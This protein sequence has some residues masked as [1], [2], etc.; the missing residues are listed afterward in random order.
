MDLEVIPYLYDN[1]FDMYIF[2]NYEEDLK[3]QNTLP[4]TFMDSLTNDIYILNNDIIYSYIFYFFCMGIIHSFSSMDYSFSNINTMIL[5]NIYLIYLINNVKNKSLYYSLFN[6]IELLGLSLISL[7]FISLIN[8]NLIYISPIIYVILF[9][10]FLF[11]HRKV[12]LE[13]NK[14]LLD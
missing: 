5:L 6:N 13:I 14:R 9:R 2:N 10:N 12:L 7:I 8:I 4:L 1:D 11:N 3:Y